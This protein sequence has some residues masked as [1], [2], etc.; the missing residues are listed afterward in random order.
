VLQ[1]CRA[2]VEERFL[3][4]DPQYRSYRERTRYRLLPFVF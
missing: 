4:A 1:V 3:D 2:R